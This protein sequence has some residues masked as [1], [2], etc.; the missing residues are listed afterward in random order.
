MAPVPRS[1]RGDECS[2]QAMS[3][4]ERAI[5]DVRRSHLDFRS[6]SVNEKAEF[7][8]RVAQIYWGQAQCL[9][10]QRDPRAE[11]YYWNSLRLCARVKEDAP[12]VMPDR[13]EFCL[14]ACSLRL[15]HA[16]KGRNILARLCQ[17]YPDSASCGEAQRLLRE[18]ERRSP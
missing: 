14:G 12:L 5:A 18:M 7:M 3:R 16:E 11:A 6:V 4:R 17:A 8:F 15:G 1:V 10:G 9:R 13:V 2:A